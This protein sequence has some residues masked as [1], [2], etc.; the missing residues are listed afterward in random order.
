MSKKSEKSKNSTISKKNPKKNEKTKNFKN[1][2][3]IIFLQ[4]LEIFEKEKNSEKKC[5]LFL[6]IRNMRFNQ[7]SPVQ[8]NPVKKNLKKSF[9]KKSSKNLKI[10]N[11]FLY[12]KKMLLS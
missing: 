3:K 1:C 7:S 9:L 11:Y 6:N 2:Q 5:S 12:R 8:P 4:N 10:L